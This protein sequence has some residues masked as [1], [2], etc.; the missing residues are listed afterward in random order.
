MTVKVYIAIPSCRDWKPQFGASMCGLVRKMT[1]DGVD[2]AINAMAQASLLP[3]ARQLAM[4]HA[5]E[6]GF[7]H[8]LFLDDDM[9][10]D[11]DLFAQLYDKDLHIVGANYSNKS[12]ARNPQAHGIDGQP[13]S[14]AGRGGIEE[15]GYLGFGAI[16]INLSAMIGV[17]KPWFE[18]RWLPERQGF[19]GEDYF[20]CM[21]AR[22]AGQRIY[23]NHAAK[24]LHMGDF[25]FREAEAA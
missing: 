2:F 4:E 6:Q 20:F 14:S 8:V 5:I 23:V 19:I 13:L 7:T 15:V 22:N 9:M 25:A 21:Q 1:Q 24:V 16:L 17:P 10:F 18:V 12:P 11:P 3:R